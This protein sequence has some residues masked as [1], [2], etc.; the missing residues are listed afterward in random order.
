MV[1]QQHVCGVVAGFSNI[2][3]RLVAPGVDILSAI[4]GGGLAFKS[5]T[6]MATPHVAGVAALW[7]D[8]M[9]QRGRPF[10]ATQVISQM[11]AAALRLPIDEAD[12]GLG[13]VQAPT[14]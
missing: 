1:E 5:G 2:G 14:A 13:L 12:V 3:V 6:S 11:E 7:S 4:P 9:L 10:Q 8:R